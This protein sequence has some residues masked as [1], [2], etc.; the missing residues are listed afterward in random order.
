MTLTICVL[1][2]QYVYFTN[3]L[4]ITV[5]LNAKR[6]N[7]LIGKKIVD[8]RKAAMYS[9][10]ILSEKLSISRSSLANIEK[11]RQ[12]CSISVL[13]EICLVLKIKPTDILPRLEEVFGLVEFRPSVEALM[14]DENIS[15]KDAK[16]IEEYLNS[17]K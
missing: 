2:K 10:T 1:N 17:I 8:H 14:V 11:G 15:K 12:Q 5:I 4:Y 13:F 7:I 6:L 3:I 9:Q 16:K